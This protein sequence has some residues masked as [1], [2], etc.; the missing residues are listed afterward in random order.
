M[1]SPRN[2]LLPVLL[3]ALFVLPAC[4]T[5]YKRVPLHDDGTTRVVLRSVV[6]G[7]EIV[8]QG[9]S[10]PKTISGIRVAHILAAL[11]VRMDGSEEEIGERVNAIPTELVF[12]LGDRVASA[13]EKADSSQEVVVQ[14]IRKQKKLGIFTHRFLT[15]FTTYVDAEDRLRIHLYRVD[16]EIPKGKED[17][18]K[19]PKPGVEAMKFRVIGGP[20]INPIGPQSVA[21]I[22]RE[23][24]F[25]K[26]SNIKI[27]PG[28]RVQ[29]RTVLMESDGI[30]NDIPEPEEVGSITDPDV[31]RDLADLEDAR[32]TGQISEGE[33][34][35]QR[36]NLL[37]YG[38]NDGIAPVDPGDGEFP[39]DHSLPPGTAE[40]QEE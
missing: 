16:W 18:I 8:D 27:G 15:S 19:E 14:A 40:K 39:G 23:E 30:L 17:D 11:D 32:R 34:S 9:Y 5:R 13:L 37:K 29:R 38:T 21:V 31:L 22:W 25:R 24:R 4:G 36:Q 20:G 1:R 28:G 7:G 10:Q 12:T 35:R 6:E 2:L 3:A 26:A 33:Y